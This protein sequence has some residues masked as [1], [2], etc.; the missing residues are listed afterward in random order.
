[1]LP[2]DK[3]G[4]VTDGPT[5]DADIDYQLQSHSLTVQFFGFESARDLIAR[6]EVGVGTRPKYDDVLTYSSEGII[7]EDV[8]GIGE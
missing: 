4:T 3:T 7:S 6:H 2:G 8:D 1:M 5:P